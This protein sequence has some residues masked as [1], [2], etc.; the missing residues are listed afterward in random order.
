MKTFAFS[1]RELTVGLRCEDTKKLRRFPDGVSIFNTF[2][3][4]S[5]S[6]ILFT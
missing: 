6:G 2:G 5:L 4:F 1:N 3:L